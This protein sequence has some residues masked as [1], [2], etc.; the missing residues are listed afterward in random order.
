MR[1]QIVCPSPDPAKYAACVMAIGPNR[2]FWELEDVQDDLRRRGVVG[3]VVFDILM[4]NGTRTTRFFAGNFDGTAFR[5]MRFEEVPGDDDLRRHSAD[6]FLARL[7][8]LDMDMLSPAKR[9]CVRH[10]MPF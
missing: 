6:F 5:P 4:A 2:P 7:E 1:H 9:Y 8:D 10:G 3:R